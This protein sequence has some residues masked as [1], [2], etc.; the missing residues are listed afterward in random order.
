MNVAGGIQ[1]PGL[2]SACGRRESL[3]CLPSELEVNVKKGKVL[4]HRVRRGTCYHLLS[5]VQYFAFVHPL[6]LPLIRC[7]L[8]PTRT[9]SRVKHWVSRHSGCP[10]QACV[11]I[12][13]VSGSTWDYQ[14]RNIDLDNPYP[15]DAFPLLSVNHV[16]CST[17]SAA[18]DIRL[19]TLTNSCSTRSVDT[20]RQPSFIH[21][22][23][24]SVR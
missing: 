23:S 21:G 11:R 20:V 16:H 12:H 18:L 22:P 4:F 14:L 19:V 9:V 8:H 1:G 10:C 7:A 15:L 2:R 17:L 3:A 6:P 24:D 5:L 13:R